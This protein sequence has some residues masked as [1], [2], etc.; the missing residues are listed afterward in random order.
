MQ[1]SNEEFLNKNVRPIMEA[2][3]EAVMIAQPEDSVS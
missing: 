3:A 2:L 1:A